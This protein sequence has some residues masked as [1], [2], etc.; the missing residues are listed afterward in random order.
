MSP[1]AVKPLK[2]PAARP[3]IMKNCPTFRR[4][5][6]NISLP[7]QVTFLPIDFTRDDLA[8]MFYR[9]GYLTDRRT[10]FIWEG[11]TYYLLADLHGRTAPV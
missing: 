4:E 5:R 10:L 1:S 8:E 9:A 6:M 7:E 3:V 2:N 11:V